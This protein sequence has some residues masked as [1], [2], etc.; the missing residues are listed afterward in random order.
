M[1]EVGGYAT[2]GIGRAEADA[3]KNVTML[4][5]FGPLAHLLRNVGISWDD[6][7]DR[8][9]VLGRCIAT[10]EPVLVEDTLTDPRVLPGPTGGVHRGVR[11]MLSLPLLV[12]G[13]V[14]GAIHADSTVPHG[15]S[16][17]DVSLLSE[18]ANNVA[19]GIRTLLAQG[20]MRAAELALYESAMAR[21]LA[22]S[23]SKTKSEFLA[24][25]SHEIRTPMNGVLG[26]TGLLLETHL[27][28]EQREY[29]E[30]VKNSGD[31]LLRIINDIL[32]YS[33][34][35]AGKLELEVLDFNL[36]TLMDEI[37]DV[38]AFRIGEKPVECAW[39]ADAE[40]P[41]QVRGDPGRLRQVLLN[42]AGNA[43]KFTMAGEVTL[44]LMVVEKSDTEVRLRIEV[45][46]SGIGI[47]P[48]KLAQL[49]VPF[50]Q[51]DSSTTRRFGGTGLGLAISKQL[52]ELM[53]G[54]IGARSVWGQ[55]SVFWFELPL[56]V[57]APEPQ[58]EP[59]APIKLVGMRV[60]VVDDNATNRRLLQILLQNWGMEVISAEDGT[61]AMH[62]LLD[63]QTAGRGV[64]V[65]ILDMQMPTMDGETLGR[66]MQANPVWAGIPLVMLTS[67]AQRGDGARLKA[68]GF[69]A[70]LTKPLKGSQLL[71]CMQTVLASPATPVAHE[72]ERTLVTRHTLADP[73]PSARVLLVED[74]AVNLKLA[75]ILLKKW[76]H[77]VLTAVNG[78]EALE[79]LRTY[80]VDL[81]LMDCH[82]PEMDGYE[83]T[84]RIRAGAAG[85]HQRDI[86]IIAL[87]ANAMV[88]DR[89]AALA[90]GMDAHI[91][92]PVD[93]QTLRAAVR[94]WHG[95][96]SGAITLFTPPPAAEHSAA[97]DSPDDVFSVV[98]LRRYY[99]GD[100]ALAA[101]VLRPLL[102]DLQ[103]QLP[104]LQQALHQQHTGEVQARLQALAAGADALGGQ[105]L[106][107]TVRALCR[108][109]DSA[110][111][112]PLA[113]EQTLL[114]CQLAALANAVTDWLALQPAGPLDTPETV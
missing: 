14:W 32:D 60:L 96:R 109:L 66:L 111:A 23:A 30:T 55:G 50:T 114:G 36:R 101:T 86:P 16:D 51:A 110:H 99:E 97:D 105:A 3:A 72:A 85:A 33:K 81:V 80:S 53:G 24:T 104:P 74:N 89:A 40:V 56:G 45:R 102:A 88:G 31:A 17:D 44:H 48:D 46:D 15:I 26:M 77:H 78:A 1:V 90:A 43:T 67:V 83:A 87:T 18:M 95:K 20:E 29:A 34:I 12:N 6:Q 49:F 73:H 92:K 8:L 84:Q 93:A 76:G 100:L 75:L 11:S 108:Q 7:G 112:T 71:R 65:A 58:V 13:V 35:E 68:A 79:V 63:A 10:G 62:V 22:E 9:G 42:L 2:V 59:L 64:D 39:L 94:H 37:A 27:S 21:Q 47:A 103:H 70:F 54:A 107:C 98:Q 113:A 19:F 61:H 41:S 4:T 82:M 25:M 91:S 57:Q 5:A 28:D 69:S 106:A 52:V 38:V